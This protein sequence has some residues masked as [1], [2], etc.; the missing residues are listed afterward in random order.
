M[1]DNHHSYQT[2]ANANQTGQHNK[3]QTLP[4]TSPLPSANLPVLS[5]RELIAAMC[6]Q[7]ILANKSIGKLTLWSTTQSAVMY[8]DELLERLKDDPGTGS[9]LTS[10]EKLAATI[11]FSGVPDICVHSGSNHEP[12]IASSR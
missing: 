5:K 10:N 3:P 7:G 9:G 4:S 11:A 12:T 1:L 8:A 6:L 2:Q